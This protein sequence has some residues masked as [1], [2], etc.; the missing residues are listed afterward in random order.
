MTGPFASRLFRVS[1]L[2]AGF[3]NLGFGA[4][5]ALWPEHFFELFAL[6]APRH[7]Q[8]WACL[9][10]VLGVYGLLYWVAAWKLELGL[11]IIAVG[12]LG[13]VLGPIGMV[14]LI[15]VDW[16]RRLAMVCIL[17]DVI[18]W[19]PFALFLIRGSAL[20]QVLQRAAPW[21][22]AGL[23]LL[24]LAAL[25]LCLRDGTELEPDIGRRAAH[26]A[27]HVGAWTAGWAVWMISAIS[28]VGFYAWWAARLPPS[29]WALAGVVIGGAGMV[30][31]LTGEGLYTLVLVERAVSVAGDPSMDPTR[32]EAVRQL[33]SLLTAGVANALYTF[34]GVILTLRT[35]GLPPWVRFSMWTTWLAG[36]GMTIS[37]LLGVTTG[38]VISSAILFP[39]LIV[40]TLWMARSWRTK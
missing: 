8:I 12:L 24:A 15:G 5:C 3:Y 23:H 16:P 1:F 26:I 17:N 34:G 39:L 11:P 22:C 25:L 29:R 35:T 21:L 32:F 9:G 7:P 19:L 38:L 28:L 31:D 40:W 18:W 10:M 33:A 2:I 36:A 37:A 6:P 14:L 20:G 4:W 13:K 27:Q 30:C